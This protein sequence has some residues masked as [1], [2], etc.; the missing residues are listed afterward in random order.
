M[1]RLYA[2][3]DNLVNMIRKVVFPFEFADGTVIPANNWIAVPQH[4]R[5]QDEN[6]YENPTTFN[7]SR[8]LNSEGKT[9]P[10]DRF[11]YPSVDFTLWGGGKNA[12]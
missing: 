10:S 1:I 4:A 12:W 11:S 5:M 8:F 9:D 6:V 7:G 2:N 3:E